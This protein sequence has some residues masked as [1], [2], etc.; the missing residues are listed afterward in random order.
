LPTIT[1]SWTLDVDDMPGWAIEDW[2][3][4]TLWPMIS[5]PQQRFEPPP[6]EWI[7]RPRPIP[8]NLPPSRSGGLVW[9]SVVEQ[10]DMYESVRGDP[11]PPIG[12]T[13]TLGRTA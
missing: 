4:I 9:S 5:H 1:A 7:P 11:P 8:T 13:D 3:V 12:S 6:A 10:I 2:G